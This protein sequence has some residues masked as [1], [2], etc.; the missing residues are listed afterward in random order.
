MTDGTPV[1]CWQDRLGLGEGIRAVD[2]GIV[3]VD[4]LTG[5]LLAG[6]ADRSAPLTQLARLSVP[7]GAVSPSTHA[8]A[9]GSRP[10]APVYA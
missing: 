7:L 3:L 5:R 4:I 2:D 9:P 8:P 6:P 10:P 1:V